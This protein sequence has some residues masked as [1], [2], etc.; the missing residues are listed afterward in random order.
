MI[1]RD[2]GAAIVGVVAM[3]FRASR[4]CRL[5]TRKRTP[6]IQLVWASRSG[7]YFVGDAVA[8][9]R[10]QYLDSSTAGVGRYRR[11]LAL[12]VVR[13]RAMSSDILRKPC[14]LDLSAAT[15]P[16][17]RGRRWTGCP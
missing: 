10:S 12:L 17:R 8:G 4:K 14:C 11:G 13:S 1:A 15:G 16:A 7:R 2:H 5:L 6:Q 9:G 3:L